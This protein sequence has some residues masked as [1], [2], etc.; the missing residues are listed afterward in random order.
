MLQRYAFASLLIQ[1]CFHPEFLVFIKIPNLHQSKVFSYQ[2]PVSLS[3][4]WL[5]NDRYLYLSTNIPAC[6]AWTML[7]NRGFSSLLLSIIPICR[8]KVEASQSRTS[9]GTASDWMSLSSS[10][11]SRSRLD[12]RNRT[13][14]QIKSEV[15]APCSKQLFLLSKPPEY[16]G[17]KKK[18]NIINGPQKNPVLFWARLVNAQHLCFKVVFSTT[19]DKGTKESEKVK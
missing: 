8:V 18:K 13:M 1:D 5:V 19:L 17:E 3:L 10:S 16:T 4:L 2:K 9:E 14:T 11:V 12:P 6:T 15:R 7:L